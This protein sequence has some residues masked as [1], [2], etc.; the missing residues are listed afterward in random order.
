MYSQYTYTS[1][2][3]SVTRGGRGNIFVE[4]SWGKLESNIF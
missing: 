4:D 3:L 1:F 2:K